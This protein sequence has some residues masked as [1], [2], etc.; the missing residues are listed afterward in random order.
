M[1]SKLSVRW[2]WE[3]CWVRAPSQ[4]RAPL[5]GETESQR[6]EN[7]IESWKPHGLEQRG[8]EAMDSGAASAEQFIYETKEVRE[9]VGTSSLTGASL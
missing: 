2:S 7:R 3:C 1:T 6:R 8:R 9:P 5:R 4:T